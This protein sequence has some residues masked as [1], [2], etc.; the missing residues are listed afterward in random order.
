MK[1]FKLLFLPLL[2]LFIAAS[3]VKKGC[4]DDL[5]ENYDA[6]AEENDQTCTYAGNVVF[7]CLPAISDSL[8]NIEGHVMLK[9]ELEGEIIDSITTETFFA[10]AGECG[11][12]GTKT[13]KREFTGNSERYYHY[14][15]KGLNNTTIYEDF[16]EIKAKNCLNIQLL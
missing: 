10:A 9:F 14:R 2:F 4:T 8:K 12:T 11:L 15:V 3:C 16:I 13:I 1:R 5:A 7:W 6:E